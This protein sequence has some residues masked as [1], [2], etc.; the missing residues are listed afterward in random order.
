MN[1][2]RLIHDRQI[3]AGEHVRIWQERN[4]QFLFE[5]LRPT[6]KWVTITCDSIDEA[7]SLWRQVEKKGLPVPFAE[8]G[9]VKVEDTSKGE[10]R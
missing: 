1:T 7:I 3:T 8:Q 6:G 4:G 10:D 9:R 5:H 2:Q